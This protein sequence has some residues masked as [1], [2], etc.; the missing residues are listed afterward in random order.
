MTETDTA[1]LKKFLAMVD[2]AS[3]IAI[4]THMHPDGDAIG[5]ATG[6]F[7][8]LESVGKSAV[9]VLNDRC[10]DSIAFLTEGAENH[11]RVY[12]N[13]KD[14]TETAI[15]GSDLIFCLDMGAFDRAENLKDA[16]QKAGCRKI[17]ID[18]HLNP[19]TG[20]FDLVFSRTEISSTSELLY[21]ILMS[22]P[23][24]CGDAGKLPVRTAKALLAGMTTDTN[25]FANSVYPS[26]FRMA[27]ELLAA[28]TDRNAVLE[29]LYHCYRE[30]RYRLMGKL[31]SE[32]MKITPEGVAYMVIDKALAAEYDLKDGETEGFVN[33]PLGIKKVRMSLLLKEEEDRFR[34]SVRSKAGTSANLCAK[35]C[36]NGGGHEL[37]AGG[38][39]LK[40][41]DLPENAGRKEAEEYVLE[42]TRN[43]LTDA[44]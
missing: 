23:E 8:Y 33:I 22:A 32:R 40:G 34:V 31:L 26:T 25:N 36:F 7:H 24:I 20:S 13:G 41:G 6:L 38:K 42:K 10:P 11:I 4:V 5:S 16:L 37:A 9:I 12:E 18:H 43:F 17:L 21:H 30:N 27:S 28:G 35:L 44:N 3:E 2:E 15:C 29:E 19:D 1:K 14:E 39:L